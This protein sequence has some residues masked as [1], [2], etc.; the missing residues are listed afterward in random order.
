MSNESEIID[1][2]NVIVKSLVN[3]IELMY[4][5]KHPEIYNLRQRLFLVMNTDETMA[6]TTL[7]PELWKHSP[8]I[9]SYNKEYFKNLN[10]M[11]E[12]GGMAKL[13]YKDFVS[14]MMKVIMND[15][16]NLSEKEKNSLYESIKQLLLLYVK[17]I[18]NRIK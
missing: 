5:E 1:E 12:I 7:G 6:L 4:V 9:L 18:R 13:M 15:Y 2:F 17:Y 8:Q 16:S 11:N 3:K 10:Y 14:K